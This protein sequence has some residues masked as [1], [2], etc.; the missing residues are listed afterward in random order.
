MATPAL[1]LESA[2]KS[3]GG[4]LW[5]LPW[6][7]GDVPSEQV[8]CNGKTAMS[9]EAVRTMNKLFNNKCSRLCNEPDSI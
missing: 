1:G 7:F 2:I 4:V 3:N 9:V 8:L 5:C 6:I